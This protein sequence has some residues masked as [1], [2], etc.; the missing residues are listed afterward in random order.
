MGRRIL[1]A[2]VAYASAS[3]ASP[4][5][6]MA[7]L[8]NRL[9][10]RRTLARYVIDAYPGVSNYNRL[11]ELRAL[12]D[13]L[14]QYARRAKN[15][16][17]RTSPTGLSRI[18]THDPRRTPVTPAIDVFTLASSVTGCQ[19]SAALG[20]SVIHITGTHQPPGST[21]AFCTTGR[22]LHLRFQTFCR[23]RRH[24]HRQHLWHRAHEERVSYTSKLSLSLYA[25]SCEISVAGAPTT[26]NVR[27]F[28]ID[29]AICGK[30][31][32]TVKCFSR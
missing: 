7:A 18:G 21:R 1:S 5:P 22:Y 8:A 31:E 2:I 23:N 30:E 9:A 17:A 12:D 16:R 11:F 28:C 14:T 15:R 27:E 19:I 25:N 20:L 3:P 24:H 6:N 10:S 13:E 29:L 26:S 4:L 32:R